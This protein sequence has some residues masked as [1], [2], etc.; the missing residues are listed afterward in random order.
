MCKFYYKN[1]FSNAD[2]VF[3]VKIEVEIT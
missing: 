3:D 2:Q 1:S